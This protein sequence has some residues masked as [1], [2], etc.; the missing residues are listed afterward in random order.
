LKKLIALFLALFIFIQG[1][2]CVITLAN[3]IVNQNEIASKYCVNQLNPSMHCNG[4]CYLKKQLK[5]TTEKQEG[6]KLLPI[7]VFAYIFEDLRE[8]DFASFARLCLYELPFA[9]H[10]NLY[11]FTFYHTIA[12]P[13]HFEAYA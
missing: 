5:Q 3:F 6:M 7:H 12:K 4:K 10:L 13:P 9:Q 2:V 8:P 1:N 11:S